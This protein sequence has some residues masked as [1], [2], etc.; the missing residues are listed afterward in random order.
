MLYVSLIVESLRTYPRLMFWSAVLAQAFLWTL[1]PTLFYAAPPGDLPILLAV[2]HEF[3]TGTDLGPPLAFWLGELAY[4]F[5]GAFGVYLLAQACIVGAFWGIFALGRRTV[6]TSHAILAVLLMVGV[7]IFSVPTAEFSPAILTLPIWTLIMLHYWRAVGEGRKAYWIP[8]S[9]E[10]GV[11]LL[12]SYLGALL[13]ALLAVFTLATARGRAALSSL[14]TWICLAIV[15]ITV[16][17]YLAWLIQAQEI[18]RPAVVRLR[19]LDTWSIDFRTLAADWGRILAG[20]AVAH[21]GAV[22]MMLLASGWPR[23]SHERVTV[24]NRA[25]VAPLVR[26]MIYFFALVPVFVV[27]FFAALS[28]QAWSLA[29]AGPLV[30]F[31]GLAIILAAGGRIRL[32]RQRLLSAAW[33]GLL[34]GPPVIVALAVVMLPWTFAVDLKVLL[35]A[36]EMG[37]FFSENFERRTGKPLAIVAGDTRLAALIALEAPSRPSLMLETTP[38]RSPWIRPADIQQKGAIVVWPATDTLGTPP[39]AIAATFPGLVVEVP[40]IFQRPIQGRLPVL[41]LGWAMIRPQG[42]QPVPA[43]R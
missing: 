19:S 43:V 39:P 4:R 24:I 13:V 8:L 36:E 21:I 40:R 2:G 10:I 37:S 3:Q 14:D 27:T 31:S 32:Y 12:T 16:F 7:A 18:W 42:D 33:I 22:F 26:S 17:P 1:V 23:A 41:R 38:E 9:L 28:G 25:P 30:V 11:L 15:L 6:G 35:P 20:L 34:V 5:G 29:N